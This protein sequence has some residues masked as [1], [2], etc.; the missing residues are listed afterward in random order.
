MLET[1]QWG[2][3]TNSL[4]NSHKTPITTSLVNSNLDIQHTPPDNK[5]SSI[6][7]LPKCTKMMAVKARKKQGQHAGEFEG[8]PQKLDINTKTDLLPLP[9][10]LT[11][12]NRC[13]SAFKDYMALVDKGMDAFN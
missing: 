1:R 12:H 13:P 5:C 7:K 10:P 11:K 9:A 2:G 8:R 4:V 6:S 3:K